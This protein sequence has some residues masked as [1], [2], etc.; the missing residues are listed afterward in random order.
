M[1]LDR[2][3]NGWLK[4]CFG[5]DWNHPKKRR[6]WWKRYRDSG[7]FPVIR[8]VEFRHSI[9]VSGPM[10]LNLAGRMNSEIF[11]VYDPNGRR[12]IVPPSETWNKG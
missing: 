9:T 12:I 7:P 10:R 6:R 5:V 4:R 2:E 3:T 8:T 11:E 1:K